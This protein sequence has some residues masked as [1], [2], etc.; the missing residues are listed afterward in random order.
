MSDSSYQNLRLS[1]KVH[2]LDWRCVTVEMLLRAA[3]DTGEV[4][5][6]VDIAYVTA[7][8]LAPLSGPVFRYHRA[9][10]GFS[11]EQISAGLRG[12]VLGL[13]YHAGGRP[14]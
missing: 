5:P 3:V 8:L 14:L 12:L 1:D 9:V 10:R 13:R 6:T 2:T 7:A 11:P 4:A